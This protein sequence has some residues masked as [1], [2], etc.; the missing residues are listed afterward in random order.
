MKI[1]HFDM[2]LDGYDV[3][4]REGLDLIIFFCQSLLQMCHCSDVKDTL[5]LPMSCFTS[6]GWDRGGLG[7][8]ARTDCVSP[9]R[10]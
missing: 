5:L 2:E 4:T 8:P 6:G 7:I 10:G 9:G 1:S 3:F